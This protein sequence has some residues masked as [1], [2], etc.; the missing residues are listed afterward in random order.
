MAPRAD[1]AG[2]MA[3]S[4]AVGVLALHLLWIAWVI[5]GWLVTRKS[6][7]LRWAHSVSLVYSIVVEIGPWPC[8][9]TLAEQNLEARAGMTPYRQ[10]FLVHYL[11]AVIY[12]DIPEVLLIVCAVAVCGFNLYL[13]SRAML[14]H[15]HGAR[16]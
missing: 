11:E 6:A 8:P 15:R 16:G 10:P 3:A 5:F 4:L 1:G 13:H 14:R 12:P 2:G 7:G 9:L